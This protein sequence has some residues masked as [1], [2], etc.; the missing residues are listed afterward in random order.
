MELITCGAVPPYRHILGGKLV[1]LLML[2]R[3]VVND[4]NERYAGRVNIIASAMA[5]RPISR[6]VRLAMLTTSS[7]YADYGRQ[8]V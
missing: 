8:P 5:G 3:Q 2:S 1:A 4:V 6:A 7:L